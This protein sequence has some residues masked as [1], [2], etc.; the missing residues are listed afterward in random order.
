MER[1]RSM[2][3]FVAIFACLAVL[4]LPSATLAWFTVPPPPEVTTILDTA[5]AQLS[6]YASPGSQDEWLNNYGGNASIRIKGAECPSL[7]KWALTS[8]KGQQVVAAELHLARS[9]TDIV[10]ALV[11]STVNTDWT[12]SLVCYRYKALASTEWTY[13]HSDA[14]TATF[15]N[16]GT[17]TCF[18]F[19]ASDTF[20]S[21]SYNGYTWIAMKLDPDLVYAMILDNPGGLAVTDARF[22]S[23]ATGGNP[24]V[25]TLNQNSTVQPRLFVQFAAGT[26]TTPPT[27]VGSLTAAAGQENG[28]VTLSFTAPSDPDDAKAFGYN[29]RYSTG[30][31]FATATDVARWRI[32]RPR[33]PGAQNQVLIEGLTAGTTYNF[34]VQAYD[35]MGNATVT[36]ASVAFAV[37][38]AVTTPTLADGGLATPDPTGK[39]V[40]T[41]SSGTLMRYFAATEACKISPTT[42]DIVGGATGD[43]YKKANM[44][45]DAGTNTISLLGCR[46]EMVGAQL[47]VQRLGASLNGVGV[48]V[49]NLAGPAGSTI[50]SNPNVELFQLHH[51]GGYP[52]AAIPLASPFSTTFSIPDANRNA[53][54]TY[55]SVWMDLYVPQTALPGDYTGTVTVTATGMTAVTVN[56]KLHVSSLMIPDYPTFLVDLNGYGN[57]WAFGTVDTT[58]LKYF[59]LCHKHRAV[60]NTLPYGWNGTI[61]ADRGPTLTGAGSTR[62][63]SSWTTFDNRYGRFFSG[64]AF[65]SGQG[66]TGPGVS[67]PI[68]HFY[69]PFNEGWPVGISDVTYGFDAAGLGEAYWYNLKNTSQW[70]VLFPTLPDLYLAFPAG[71]KQGH[72]N[73]ISDWFNHAHTNGWTR[74]AFEIYFNE[75]YSYNGAH[76]FWEM[77]ENGAADDFYADGYYHGLYREGQAASGVTDVPWHFRIDISDRYGQNWGQLNNRINWWDLG[78]GAAGWHWPQKKYRQY[79]IDSDKQEGWMWY[80]LGSSIS[81]GGLGNAQAFLQKWSQGYNAGLPWWDCYQTSWGSVND[82]S[83]VYAGGGSYSVPGYG[84]YNGA[85]IS[86]RVKEVRQVQQVIELLNMWAGSGATNINRSRVRDSLSAKYGTGSWDYAFTGIDE[87]KLHKL[88]ADLI[89]QLEPILLPAAPANP[90]PANAAT[91]VSTSP[92]LTWSGAASGVTF[93]VYF[94][95]ANPPVTKVVSAQAAASYT[96]ATLA[97]GTTYYWQVASINS[98]GSTLGSVWSFTTAAVSPPAAPS[99]PSPANGATNVA[100]NVTLSWTGAGSGITFDVYLD[101]VNPPVAKVST[102]QSAG[103]YGP[104]ALARATTYYWKIVAINAGG[105]TAGSVWS[106]T[107]IPNAPPAPGSPNPA[108]SA[109]NVAISA[110]LTWSGAGSGITFDVYLDTVNPPVAKVATGQSAA[111]FTS[112]KLEATTYYWKIVAINAGGQTAGP[113]WSFLTY[114]PGDV[115]GDGH[116]DVIDLLYFVDAFGSVAGDPTYDPAADF[117]HNDSI[118]VIDLLIFVDYFGVY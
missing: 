61:Q 7:F 97:A 102:A 106:F 91:G 107:T 76:V 24:T 115:N 9:N 84:A 23:A 85:C 35:K 22:H 1:E 8:Y 51:V 54:G 28:S 25:Y 71:Y 37:P 99:N 93:D 114:I 63:A 13:S 89:A 92:T 16:F 104:T 90:S 6:S 103:T 57:P 17:L 46:N 78:S 79:H 33:V 18:G 100:T 58:C 43:N 20:K 4:C 77:E 38:A 75:K 3:T 49:G 15:G 82:L 2:R 67:T 10:S 68:T 30:T 19:S 56:L 12:E 108:D 69:S 118:D 117:D 81:G 80:G 27:A 112:T 36:P 110:T 109:T 29:V 5:D 73:V 83:V 96:P 72:M 95:T 48:S 26:D 55:Q 50:A 52:D 60:C 87:T 113:V 105:Q 42:G 45:W 41:D 64:T 98:N 40:R 44:V 88:R 101:T 86:I 53:G 94:G 66:Y 70:S 65:T 74:T 11:A 47:I 116:V 62:H 111:T 34:W 39:T 14:T 21:Y 32:P 31:N 59:Q